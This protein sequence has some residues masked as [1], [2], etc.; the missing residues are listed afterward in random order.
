MT[1]LVKQTAAMAVTALCRNRIEEQVIRAYVH[2]AF[3]PDQGNR[4]RTLIVARFGALEIRMSENLQEEGPPL[5]PPFRIE[6][7]SHVND[8]VL[9]SGD[10]FEFDEDELEAAVELIFSAQV[11]QPA[12]H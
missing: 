6:I 9:D 2:L 11:N 3:M 1:Q 10:Y 8:T 4:L 12:L 5:A 7:Y